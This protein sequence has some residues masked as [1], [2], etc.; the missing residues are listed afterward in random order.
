MKQRSA[1]RKFAFQFFYNKVFN[2]SVN[3]IKKEDL[4]R[5]IQFFKK[6]LQLPVEQEEFVSNL[7]LIASINF[8]E[9]LQ[10]IEEN[11]QNWRLDRVD[12]ITKTLLI[13]AITEMNFLEEKT[14]GKVVINEYIELAKE[15]G[16]K[17]SKSFING[18]LDRIHNGKK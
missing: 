17:D 12:H 7:I 6:S 10:L 3:E 11:I 8:Q 9:T 15:F 13:L 2:N 16:N 5:E 1:G 4:I 14:P 18:V